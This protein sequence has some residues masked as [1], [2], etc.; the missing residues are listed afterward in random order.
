MVI[1][2]FIS[3][4]DVQHSVKHMFDFDELKLISKQKTPK[5]IV[6]CVTFVGNFYLSHYLLNN[7]NFFPSMYI[8]LVKEKNLYINFHNMQQVLYIKQI[9][10]TS[11]FKYKTF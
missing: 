1:I 2:F 10:N 4:D 3:K 8:F 6:S 9:F 7:G 5:C 11:V